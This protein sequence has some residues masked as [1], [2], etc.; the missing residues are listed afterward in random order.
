MQRMNKF[1]FNFINFKEKVCELN[2]YKKLFN[3]SIIFAIGRLGSKLVTFLLVPLY[4]YYLST[5]EYGTVDLV[6]ATANM[7]LPIVSGSIFQAV[8]RFV[9]EDKEN[10]DKIM[11]NALVIT[12]I[13]YF[14]SILF[15]PIIVATNLLGNSNVVLFMYIILFVQIFERIFA[16]YTR[17]IGEIK[18]F[19]L[20]GIILSLSIAVLNIIFLVGFGFGVEGYFYS[21]ILANLISILFL[22]LSTNIFSHFDF[23]KIRV[24]FMR[25]LMVYSIPLIPNS[26]MWWIINASSKYFI[27]VFVS[28]G[29]NGLFAVASRVPTLLNVVNQ[30]FMQAWQLS[31]IEEYEN[32]N[33]SVFYSNVFN[34]LSS[35]LFIGTSFILIILK[36][37]FRFAFA[38]DYFV[39]WKAVPFLLLGAVF[40]SFSGFLGT[41]YIASKQ[42]GGVFKTSVYGGIISIIL[43]FIIIPNFG[44]IGAGVSSMLSFLVMWLLRLY[45]TRRFVTINTNWKKL[46]SNVL[47]ILTQ[48][49]VMWL[50]I[51]ETFEIILSSILF[52]FLLVINRDLIRLFLKMMR[53]FIRR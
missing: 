5:A 8:L 53:G 23:S 33:K 39:A 22:T 36:P 50:G 27:R 26:L 20:N 42:T 48:I 37:A 41:N 4:T 1:V 35:I 19:A 32:E 52:I 43:N 47:I 14:I 10:A 6:I 45:D 34:Y 30:I 28:V 9:I 11:T 7:L 31:A 16:E 15:F 51:S 46:I 49:L 2:S 40:S 13:G 18:K 24:K 12:L 3:N 21:F 38:S 25:K 29:A 44:L 17:A